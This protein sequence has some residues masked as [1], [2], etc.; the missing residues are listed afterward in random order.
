VLGDGKE[1]WHS[2]GL[3]KADGAK[4]VKV[5]VKNVRR[6]MLRVT[7]EGEGGRVHADWVDAKLI[8]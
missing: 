1:L 8:K 4:P 2:G 6:L 3:K 7:R 5:D